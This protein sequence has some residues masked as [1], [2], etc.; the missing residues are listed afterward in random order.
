MQNLKHV[1]KNMSTMLLKLTGKHFVSWA[2]LSK[3]LAL[4]PARGLIL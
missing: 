3:F 4:K 1:S 2:Q